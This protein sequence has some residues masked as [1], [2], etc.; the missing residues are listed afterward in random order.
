[1]CQ[2]NVGHLACLSKKF[3]NNLDYLGIFGRAIEIPVSRHL[4]RNKP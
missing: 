4:L 3:R 2:T 1:M